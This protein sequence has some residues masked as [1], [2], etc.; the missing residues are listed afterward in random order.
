M[1]PAPGTQRR[2]TVSAI[3]ILGRVRCSSQGRRLSGAMRLSWPESIEGVA[4]MANRGG[5][6]RRAFSPRVVLRGLR[7]I[8]AGVG[9]HTSACFDS[10]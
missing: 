8:D 10:H 9:T 6:R 7:I 1:V 5:L 3:G 2:S 4:S